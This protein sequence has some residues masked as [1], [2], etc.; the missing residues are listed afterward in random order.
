VDHADPASGDF[1]LEATRAT[2][3]A[4][5]NL[6]AAAASWT[7]NADGRTRGAMCAPS[8]VIRWASQYAMDTPKLFRLSVVFPLYLNE[9]GLIAV[10]SANLFIGTQRSLRSVPRSVFRVPP[11]PR[12][13]PPDSVRLQQIRS[14][15]CWTLACTIPAASKR[16]DIAVKPAT[17]RGRG[18]K[19][20]KRH[21][22]WYR[23]GSCGRNIRVHCER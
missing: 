12:R 5:A 20:K 11:P 7:R 14:S 6:Q 10:G 17:V 8:R 16:S 21:L 22:K 23:Y 15:R 13:R 18:D 9:F 2:S 4:Q 3:F 19:K 1:T